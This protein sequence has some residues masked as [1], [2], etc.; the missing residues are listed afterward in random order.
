M[1]QGTGS[2]VGK[3]L[4]VAGLCRALRN[5]GLAVA[6]FKPQNMSNNAA[7]TGDGGEIG[8]AQALQARAAKIPPTADM[9]PVLLKPENDLGSLVVVQGRAEGFVRGMEY[10]D[11]RGKLMPRVMESFERLC[12]SYDAVVVEGAGSSSEVNLRDGDIANMG[13]AL[14]A[15]VPVLLA[16]DIDR[17][18]AIASIVGAHALA[19]A[20]ERA[21][22]KGYVINKFR[23]SVPLFNPAL[24]TIREHTGLEP[25]GI[26]RWFADATLL[27]AEDSAALERNR[28]LAGS[29]G[30]ARIGISVLQLPGI[31]NFDDFDPL[32]AE[33]DVRLSFVKPKEAIPGDVRLVIIPG[34]K[35]AIAGAEYIRAQ[36][37][38]IDIAAHIRRGGHVLGICGGYHIMGMEISGP[39]D[40]GGPAAVRGLGLLDIA[41]VQGRAGAP[42]KFRAE[43]E[44]GHK[45]AGYDTGTG[46]TTGPETKSPMLVLD[47]RPEGAVSR[48]GL[49]YGCNVHGLF[50]FDG[51]RGEFLKRFRSGRL[52]DASPLRYENR[53][54]AILDSLADQIE[55]DLDVKR[56][57]HIAGVEI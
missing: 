52:A 36:G 54:E 33:D 44:E 30:A 19:T 4:L 51:Y 39:N 41:T 6:P 28:K 43:T 55:S 21:A 3:S 34:T 23:G 12:A 49:A 8:R 48:D 40:A 10:R 25:L 2:D 26:M 31:S 47:G 57:M 38:D 11:F 46:V 32:A 15:E 14:H 29:G 24:E 56:I 9:N 16:A 42:R 17:G 5:R 53:I 50:A 22:L 45:I 1:F 7:I 18:G 37:W 27:P 35:S 20:S 13:F